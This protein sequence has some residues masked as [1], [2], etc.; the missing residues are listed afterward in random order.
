MNIYYSQFYYQAGSSF[1]FSY[2]FQ[3]YLSE[4]TTRL[5]KPSTRF[6]ELH[7]EDYSLMFRISAKRELAINEIVGPTVYKKDKDVEYSIFLPY[8]PIIQQ[9]EPYISALEHILEGAYEIL[10]DYEI[11]TSKLKAEQGVIINNIVTLPEMFVQKE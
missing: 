10:D 4:E 8:T 7:G 2:K 9:S 6:I 11:D 1:P 3:I 5:V